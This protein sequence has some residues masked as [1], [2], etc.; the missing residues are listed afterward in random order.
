MKI[1]KP[2]T[3]D[4]T[5]T[6]RIKTEMLKRLEQIAKKENVSVSEVIRQA[7]ERGIN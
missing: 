3:I 7:I 2:E 6:I 5:I 1:K 4:E